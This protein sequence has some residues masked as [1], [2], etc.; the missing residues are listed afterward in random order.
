ML[1]FLQTQE[2]KFFL[3]YESLSIFLQSSP[4]PPPAE[5]EHPETEINYFQ[6]TTMNT[7]TAFI[8]HKKP[9]AKLKAG[10]H[11]N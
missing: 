10:G 4:Y 11:L 5:S 2:H 8:K 1:F 9:P 3:E 6:K 7:K